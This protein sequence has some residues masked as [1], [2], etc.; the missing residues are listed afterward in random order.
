MKQIM[1][2][3]AYLIYLMKREMP[4]AAKEA[5]E[6]F[7][8]LV[9]Y[10]MKEMDIKREPATLK[11]AGLYNQEAKKDNPHLSAVEISKAARAIFDNETRENREKRYAK[12]K[13]AVAAKISAKQAKYA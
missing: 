4:A 13:E 11:L 1:P 5:S 3:E 10:I 6:A 8:F 2:A 9:K 7:G 12:A